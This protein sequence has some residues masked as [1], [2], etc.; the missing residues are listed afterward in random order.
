MFRS[1]RTEGAPDVTLTIN[2]QSVTV[3]AGQSV[4]SALALGGQQVTRRAALSGQA[5]SAYCA[6]GVCFE[7]MME[8]NGLPNQQSCL[9][10]VETGMIVNTQT[11]HDESKTTDAQL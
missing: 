2:G 11:I 5:R 8:I 3:P 9:R 1:L 7:C 6:M 10:Q 4:W